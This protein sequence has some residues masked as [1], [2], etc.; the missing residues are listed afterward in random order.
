MQ[1]CIHS[2][3]GNWL[4]FWYQSG[5]VTQQMCC[6]QGYQ[7]DIAG[8]LLSMKNETLCHPRPIKATADPRPCILILNT[9]IVE[10]HATGTTTHRA[11]TCT[12]SC[13]WLRKEKR[14]VTYF[15]VYS[16]FSLMTVWLLILLD[17]LAGIRLTSLQ[18]PFS[19]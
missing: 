16:I 6:K 5:A 4:I 19:V 3:L 1:F 17:I 15:V 13:S 7:R 14:L 12:C 10:M 11:H 9:K 2:S 18:M 8:M